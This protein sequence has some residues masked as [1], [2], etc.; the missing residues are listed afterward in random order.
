M[1]VERDWHGVRAVCLLCG[2]AIDLDL[3]AA[4][5]PALENMSVAEDDGR[6]PYCATPMPTNAPSTSWLYCE[7]C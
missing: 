2:R 6:C 7:A 1:F 3:S 5:P 4:G